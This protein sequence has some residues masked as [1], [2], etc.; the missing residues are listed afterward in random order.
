MNP[1]RQKKKRRGLFSLYH[2]LF[3]HSYIPASFAA[4]SLCGTVF[5][6][7]EAFFTSYISLKNPLSQILVE[8]HQRLENL[9][10]FG[11]QKHTMEFDKGLKEI[12]KLLE[13]SPA[14]QEQLRR[15]GISLEKLINKIPEIIA[16]TEQLPLEEAPYYRDITKAVLAT[17]SKHLPAALKKHDSNQIDWPRIN[18]ILKNIAAFD[19]QNPR[20]SLFKIKRAIEGRYSLREFI[21]CRV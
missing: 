1:H 9:K 11:R 12:V 3:L 7:R 17:F 8:G 5:I 20:S 18:L 6:G 14:Q 2:F 16:F 21:L 10:W 19:K 15:A 13:H 4:I